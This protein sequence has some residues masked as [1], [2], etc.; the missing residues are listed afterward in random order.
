MRFP[1]PLPSK[2]DDKIAGP[3]LPP[4]PNGTQLQSSRLWLAVLCW[5]G[6]R[7]GCWLVKCFMMVCHNLFN[8]WRK[9]QSARRILGPE[10]DFSCVDQW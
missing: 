1:T 4:Y 9:D 10:K 7:A 8:W 6:L 2:I 3:Y 5:L